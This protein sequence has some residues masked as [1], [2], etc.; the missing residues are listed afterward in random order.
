ML[1]K[2][3]DGGIKRLEIPSAE[4]LNYIFHYDGKDIIRNYSAGRSRAG[5]VATRLH[6]NGYLC[7]N[8]DGVR[9]MAHRIIWKMIHGDV[10]DVIDHINRVKHDNRIE[11]LRSSDA[12]RNRSNTGIMSNNTT[13][14]IGVYWY[15]YKGT[16]RWRAA[17]DDKHI[18]YFNNIAS[19][20]SA[21][22]KTVYERYGE[23]S[24]VKINHNKNKKVYFYHQ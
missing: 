18:G 7:V 13:G 12:E 10:P 17:C 14:I 6:V 23:E 19:A 8:V 5:S 24:L 22:N 21:Y 1:L 2:S 16:P 11:N 15:D 3:T 4:K 9:F 20:A